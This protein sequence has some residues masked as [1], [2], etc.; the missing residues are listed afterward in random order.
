MKLWIVLLTIVL[1]GCSQTVAVNG[2]MQ[3]Q[4][5][6]SV[7]PANPGLARFQTGPADVE[8]AVAPASKLVSEV[9][10]QQGQQQLPI[11]L[12][13]VHWGQGSLV[14]QLQQ[15]QL[16]GSLR[17]NW[18]HDSP[19]LQRRAYESCTYNGWCD[20]EEA[21]DTEVC[22]IQEGKRVCKTVTE[23]RIVHG[24]HVGCPG[25]EPVAITEQYSHALLNV[26]LQ[27]PA[28]S[29]LTFSGRSPSD[30]FE[31][32]RQVVGECR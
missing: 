22:E 29:K 21:F 24:Y 6:A 2:Y 3:V 1:A 15:Q 12:K 27:D 17:L 7:D 28:G 8:L 14:L 26:D 10:L 5:A 13:E 30:L 16:Q 31:L 23:W 32:D 18:V 20:Y 25:E 19:P 11:A 9:R 4:A